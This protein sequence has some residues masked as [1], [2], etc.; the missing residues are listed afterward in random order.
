[1]NSKA[2][3][4]AGPSEGVLEDVHPELSPPILRDARH[5]EPHLIGPEL[6]LEQEGRPQQPQLV[7]LVPADRFMGPSQSRTASCLDLAEHEGPVPKQYEVQ[8]AER[9][10]PVA[11]D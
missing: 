1:M 5:V 8:L 9:A 2:G 11:G 6:R 7:L 3:P 4:S 10:S